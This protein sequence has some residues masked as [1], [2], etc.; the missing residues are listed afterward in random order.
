[1]AGYGVVIGGVVGLSQELEL[2]AP[3][4]GLRADC[5][6]C[7]GLCCVALP[8]TA[9]ADFAI[10]KPAGEPCPNLREDFRCGVH[11]EL[12]ERGFPGCVAFDC[13]GAGPKVSEVPFGGRSWRAAPETA[14]AMYAA[15]P[16]MLRLHELLWYVTEA[17]TLPAAGPV[18]E[19]LRAMR[20]ELDG[21]TT[22]AAEELTEL[23]TVALRGRMDVLLRRASELVRGQ[24]P[25]G[26]DRTGADLMG[27]RLRGADLRGWNL[28]GAYLIAADLRGADLTAADLIG[29]DLRDAD[30]RGADLS[31]A[32]FVTQAQVNAAKG[33]DATRLPPM[34][35]RPAHWA[36]A[37]A[38]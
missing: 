8:L 26:R 28:R 19:P 9:S 36:G 12:R 35:L 2:A 21:L 20:A 24:A 30:L 17:L 37:S 22:S 14:P 7:F 32:V 18:H 6:R 29:A 31:G 16:V 4:D 34:P 15:F 23:D 13:F 1:M 10:D 3:A 38:R 25:G 11:A 33:D 5:D 27:A